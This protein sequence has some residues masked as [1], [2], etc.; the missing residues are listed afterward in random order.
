MLFS[1][2]STRVSAC[3]TES[4]TGAVKV[5][6]HEEPRT[7]TF[8]EQK[9]LLTRKLVQAR[10]EAAFEEWMQERRDSLGVEIHDDVLDLMG[11]PVS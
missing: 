3:F 10:G 11:Q 4:S 2:A 5:L 7:S 1:D 8:E 6:A 9:D